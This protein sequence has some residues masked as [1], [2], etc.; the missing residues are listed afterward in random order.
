MTK[1]GKNNGT[2]Q[3]KGLGTG[4][5]CGKNKGEA[6]GVGGHCICAKC[7]AKVAHQ[8]G[9]KCTTLKCTSCGK[10]MVREE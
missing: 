3:G 6:H 5:G 4:G 7:G 2:N 1:L 9:V 8:Q 10:N